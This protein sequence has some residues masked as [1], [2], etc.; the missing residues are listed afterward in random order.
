MNHKPQKALP[1]ANVI[2]GMHPVMEA[3]HSD[4]PLDKI[5]LKQG[6]QPDRIK[7]IKNLAKS[8][9]IP[10][11]VVPEAALKKWVR[12]GNHQG[13]VAF[14]AP[15]RFQA[16]EEVVI[17]INESGQ[18]PLLLML[19]GVSDVRNFGAIAR[20]AECMGVHAIV[21]PAKRAA[22]LNATAMKI[23]AGALLHIPICRENNLVDS[24]LLL[25][26][27]DIQCVACTE[28]ASDTIFDIP[29]Q[30][31]TCLIMGS[32][33]KGITSALLKR[34]DQLA[35]IPLKGKIGS[36]NVSVAA[37]M[38]LSEAARQRRSD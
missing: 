15:V 29:M 36:L 16:L 11:Q 4:E 3:L 2:F 22:A 28:K 13:I 9:Q 19:D 30:T 23:S 1:K 10:V 7:E 27:Y 21:V 34:A 38:V 33:E 35:G 26:A 20:T 12:H 31:P 17:R 25:Q 5:L 14:V 8:R 24:L 37:G 6:I 18:T 32:E